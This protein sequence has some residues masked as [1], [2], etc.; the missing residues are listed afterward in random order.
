[1]SLAILEK[2]VVGW[3]QCMAFPY[4]PLAKFKAFQSQRYS[5]T[6]FFK[7]VHLA[8]TCRARGVFRQFIY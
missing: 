4:M 7:G 1:V 3:W 5:M 8:N 6:P 2:V